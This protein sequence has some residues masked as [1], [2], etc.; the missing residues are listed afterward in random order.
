[1]IHEIEVL[2]A[3]M[4]AEHNG[5]CPQVAVDWERQGSCADRCRPGFAS[6]CW[7]RWAGEELRD[8]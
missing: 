1:M 7:R 3:R 8:Q 6:E 5:L 4:E 2:A